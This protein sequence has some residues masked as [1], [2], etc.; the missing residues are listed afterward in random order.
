MPSDILLEI[1]DPEIEGES[2]DSKH[3]GAI[4]ILACDYGMEQETAMQT[5]AGLVAGG[6]SMDRI[7]IAKLF[8]KATLKLF[9]MCVTGSKIEHARI[10]FRRP[11]EAGSTFTSNEPVEFQVIDLKRVSVVSIRESGNGGS[12]IPNESIEFAA[13]TFIMHY[14]EIKDGQPQPAISKGYNFKSNDVQDA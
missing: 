13:E 7:S 11:G 9:Q 4:E 2:K 14:R 1:L 6:S 8:D 5:G 10:I 3:P 12:A